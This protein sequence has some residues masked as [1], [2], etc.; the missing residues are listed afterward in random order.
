MFLLWRETVLS[1]TR[2]PHIW[3]PLLCPAV[4]IFRQVQLC[5]K[6]P[7]VSQRPR[8]AEEVDGKIKGQN[9]TVT[10]HT[11]VCSRHFLS[12]DLIEPTN[13]DGRRR[14]KSGTVPVLFQWNNFTV[15]SL[16]GTKGTNVRDTETAQME[17]RLIDK[18]SSSVSLTMDMDQWV[19]VKQ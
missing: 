4:R 18:P 12:T 19:N 15:A 7:H 14:L 16:P 11:R 8:I 1:K 9:L 6:F 5:I 3:T 17:D 10:S 2:R 13:P